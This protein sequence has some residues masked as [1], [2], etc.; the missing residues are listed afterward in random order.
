MV[1]V[2]FANDSSQG[3]PIEAPRPCNAIRL[4]NFAMVL[5]PKM[6]LGSTAKQL[7]YSNSNTCNQGGRFCNRLFGGFWLA[8]PLLA[9]RLA[10]YH[11]LDHGAELVITLF[12]GFHDFFYRFAVSRRQSPP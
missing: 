9:E 12:G 8:S 10:V 3:K 5:S 7:V 11:G 1:P 4:L 2:A 6:L